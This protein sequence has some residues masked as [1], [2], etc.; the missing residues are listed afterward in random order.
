MI[1]TIIRIFKLPNKIEI[2]I[3]IQITYKKILVEKIIKNKFTI[4]SK[5]KK[6][7]ISSS[8]NKIFKLNS[9]NILRI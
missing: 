7:C 2:K 9:R 4:F 8:N 6:T 5:N 3:I 1:I